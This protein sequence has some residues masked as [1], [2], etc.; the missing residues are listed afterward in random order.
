METK[1]TADGKKVAVLGKLNNEEWI[2][3]EIYVDDGREFPAGE[4]FVCKTLLDTPS[5]THLSYRVERQEMELAK[6]D[7]EIEEIRKKQRE[8]TRTYNRDAITER[9]RG[10][11]R[12]FALEELDTLFDFL[13]DEITHV[14]MRKWRGYGIVEFGKAIEDA[15]G[16]HFDGLKLVSLFGTRSNGARND[17]ERSLTLDWRINQY[18]DGSGSWKEI[19]PFKS[20]EAA[21]EYIDDAIKDEDAT[22]TN[23]EMKGKYGLRNPTDDKIQVY[24]DKRLAKLSSHIE[25]KEKELDALRENM[26]SS[27]LKK[28]NTGEINDGGD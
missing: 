10:I 18:R 7:K 5:K 24:E 19:I 11:Q 22:E 20:Y 3:Q 2:V 8:L 4:N 14:V 25:K 9:V 15:D 16:T 23:I 21:V 12:K 6:L 1:Y 26:T 13:N 27:S 17:N 28:S